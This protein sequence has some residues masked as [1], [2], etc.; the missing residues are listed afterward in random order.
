[1]GTHFTLVADTYSVRVT[2]NAK[3]GTASVHFTVNIGPDVA[4]T[5]PWDPRTYPFDSATGR[6]DQ[7][8]ALTLRPTSISLSKDG[9]VLEK[10]RTPANGVAQVLVKAK[11][12]VVSESTLG[13]TVRVYD[14]NSTTARVIVE[15]SDL[16]AGAPKSDGA[17]GLALIMR[18]DTITSTNDGISPTGGAGG[19][20]SLIEYNK[21]TRDGSRIGTE[22][23][24]GI[25][26]WQGGNAVIRRNWIDGWNTSAIMLKSDLEWHVGDG[27]IS[28]VLIEENYLNNP[29]GQVTLYVR[30]GHFGRPE[31]VTIRNNAFGTGA[32]PISSGSGPS[33][34]AVFVRTERERSDAVAAGDRSA[35]TW[36]VW[37]GNYWADTG[38]EI[39]P[40]GGWRS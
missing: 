25:Q 17:F 31:Y 10:V 30:A 1:M 15:H 40:P 7:S 27:P 18:Y 2:N 11:D 26:L 14:S 13:G 29:T 9:Q 23:Q 33:D 36:I 6:S 28:N 19:P 21:I 16:A 39:V 12:A 37:S 4:A 38:K 35:A 22:H 32:T 34:E 3:A 5:P 8:A 20:Q 24:D